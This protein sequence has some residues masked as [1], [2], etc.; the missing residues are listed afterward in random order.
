MTATN[1]TGLKGL[2]LSESFNRNRTRSHQRPN[3]DYLHQRPP[4]RLDLTQMD[5]ETFRY[6]FRIVGNTT[7]ERRLTDW[8]AAFRGCSECDERAEPKRES[9]LSA[10]AFGDD[11]R[12][13]LAATG[14]TKGYDG[15][16]WATWLWFDID[17]DDIE[18]ATRDAR[19]LAAGLVDRYKLDADE[20]L[21][22][23]S[24]SKGFHIGLPLSVC[25]SRNRRKPFI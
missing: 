13:H 3:C 25:G 11:F 1:A 20:L 21:A 23:F 5:Y 8:A 7:N 10:F 2:R 6:G 9:Y 19:R 14:S 18:Q 24:G 12:R 22:F 15:A 16:T 4:H 17:R